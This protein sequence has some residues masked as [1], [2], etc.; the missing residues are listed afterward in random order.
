M[1][2]PK[3]LLCA[4][5]GLSA[6]ATASAQTILIDFG[7]TGTA[8]TPSPTGGNYWNNFNTPASGSAALVT[9]TNAA[10]GIT[11]TVSSTFANTGPSP[12]A[13]LTGSSTLGNLNVSTALSDFFYGN[14]N[15]GSP[16]TLTFSG[17]NAGYTYTFSM[18]G[19]RSATDSR[20]TTYVV[21]G[22]TSGTAT[23]QTS[24]LDIGG[25]GINY[26][27]SNLAVIS[28][29]TP[30][31]SNNITLAVSATGFSYL[32]A[33]QISVIPEPTAVMLILG[34]FGGVVLMRRR[35]KPLE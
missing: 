22:A 29:I 25:S 7:M 31:G 14:N 17:L 3:F 20:T 27:N 12:Y 8:A 5:F 15:V 24:G 33:L 18:L 19:A 6:F 26:N 1:K 13:T 34:V 28:G 21:A 35:R 10:S 23:L 4:L 30:D 9:T 11:M 2:L 32:N 16:A